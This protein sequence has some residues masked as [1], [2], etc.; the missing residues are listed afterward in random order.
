MEAGNIVAIPG[1]AFYLGKPQASVELVA[2]LLA[3]AAVACFL[4]VGALYWR[5]PDRRFR[6]ADR[7]ALSGSLGVADR[8]EKPGLVL[9][10]LA[11]VAC[12]VALALQAWSTAVVAASILSLLAAVEYVNYY[13][14]Q[15]QHFDNAADFKRLLTGGGLKPS[16]MARDLAAFRRR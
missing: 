9:I 16:H 7:T 6:S 14:R 5:G 12:A 10:A 3:S 1:L 13:R 2:L 8:A 11:V 15:L 4:L